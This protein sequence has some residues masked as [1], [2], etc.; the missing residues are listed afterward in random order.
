MASSLNLARVQGR[1]NELNIPA[2]NVLSLY[3]L[4][5]VQDV[6]MLRGNLEYVAGFEVTPAAP[7]TLPPLEASPSLPELHANPPPR[8]NTF[9]ASEAKSSS[10]KKTEKK[11]IY[12][13]STPPQSGMHQVF[14]Q[15]PQTASVKPRLADSMFISPQKVLAETITSPQVWWEISEVQPKSMRKSPKPLD[16][17]EPLLSKSGNK[18]RAHER[19][20]LKA[21]PLPTKFSTLLEKELLRAR[22]P[23]RGVNEILAECGT[24]LH[25]FK[26]G[27]RYNDDDDD[28]DEDLPEL[29]KPAPRSRWSMFNRKP[30]PP[31]ELPKQNQADATHWEEEDMYDPDMETP[32]PEECEER[33]SQ[34]SQI[35]TAALQANPLA[36]DEYA[37]AQNRMKIENKLKLAAKEL[38]ALQD[39]PWNRKLSGRFNQCISDVHVNRPHFMAPVWKP[40]R[41]RRAQFT[42][43]PPTEAQRPMT[44]PWHIEQSC[45]GPRNRESDSRAYL[46]TKAVLK[47]QLKKDWENTR[48]KANFQ[49]AILR[50]Y[51][52]NPQLDTGVYPNIDQ[53]LEALHGVF[54]SHYGL[55]SRLFTYMC[56]SGDSV[57]ESAYSIKINTWNH[58]VKICYLAD[59]KSAHCRAVDIDSAF[60]ATNYEEA[61]NDDLND[62]NDDQAL[63]RFEFLE[64]LCRVAIMKYGMGEATHDAAEALEM[65]LSNDVIPG[66]PPECFMDPDLFR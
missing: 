63:M 19:K 55:I 51:K 54:L 36:H 66:L 44:P 11:S 62:E 42:D 7:S 45:F 31:Q 43:E 4:Q 30:D 15:D 47:R 32:E 10:K 60:V 24:S 41:P 8:L 46:D 56:M 39:T 64:I 28:T 59:P 49:K 12:K 1:S 29:K 16:Y 2:V 33:P 13:D 5:E 9:V 50:C 58:L 52:N 17:F 57:G 26:K 34:R 21:S 61:G 25:E 27:L 6:R 18:S 3:R 37:A 65:M 53:V 22:A 14:P 35:A 23:V 40:E 48:S 20:S 38:Q